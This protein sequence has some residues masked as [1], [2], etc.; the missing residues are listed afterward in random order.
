MSHFLENVS[1]PPRNI[2]KNV[3]WLKPFSHSSGIFFRLCYSALK[4]IDHKTLDHN[5]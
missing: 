1:I 2:F 5:P 4:Y 3:V